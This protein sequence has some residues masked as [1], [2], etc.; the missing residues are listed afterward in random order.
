VSKHPGLFPG[1]KISATDPDLAFADA[2]RGETGTMCDTSAETKLYS[3]AS[4]AE[5]EFHSVDTEDA[6]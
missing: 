2:Q 5:L 4:G 3:Q 1:F 6:H